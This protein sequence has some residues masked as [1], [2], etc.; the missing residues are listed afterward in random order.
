MTDYFE[1]WLKYQHPIVRQLAFCIASP[2][3]IQALPDELQI[4]HHFELH[5]TEFWQQQFLAYQTRLDDLDQNPTTLI[6]FVQQL[7]STRLGL[8]FEYLFWFWLQDEANPHY[9]LIQHSIQIIE[10]KHTKGEIDFL[11]LNRLTQQI[12]HWEVALKYYLGEADLHLARWYGLNRSDTLFR[13]LN[14]F[15][16]KQFQFSQVLDRN[17]EK[18][19]AV[20]KGQLYIPYFRHT[21]PLPSW[22]NQQRRLGQ[23]GQHIEQGLYRLQRHEWICPDLKQSSTTAQWWCNGL[24]HDHHTQQFYMYRQAP[25]LSSLDTKT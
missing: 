2:N 3:I 20:L 16:E 15:S 21:A 14:H 12:E 1:P 25:L 13:K 11:V 6:E 10:G 4:H 9:Q 8:R 17:I 18:K 22:I 19:W 5:N 24:Y 23:W 7:K